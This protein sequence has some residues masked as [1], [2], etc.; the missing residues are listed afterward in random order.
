[1]TVWDVVGTGFDG[2][3]VPRGKHGVGTGVMKELSDDDIKWR[4]SRMREVLNALGPKAWRKPRNEGSSDA[5]NFATAF[6]DQDFA[7]LSAGE[8]R[9]VILMR[10]LV[11][12][13]Q[14][15]LLDEAWSAMDDAMVSA[16]RRYLREGGISED[17]AVVVI[18]H[19]EDEVPWNSEDGVKTFQ[20]TQGEGNIVS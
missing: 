6:E 17:Q 9:I 11:G 15:V 8:Q 7:D 19:W 16:A 12:R 5:T 10:A 3:F 1:M 18:T 14:L 20:L 13:P 4:V 2:N